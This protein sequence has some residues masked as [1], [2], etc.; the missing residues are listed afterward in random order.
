M[1]PLLLPVGR[2]VAVTA[3]LT[4]TTVTLVAALANPRRPPWHEIIPEPQGWTRAI[5]QLRPGMTRQEV[6]DLLG[7]PVEVHR[8]GGPYVYQETYEYP[9]H[10][11]QQPLSL[12]FDA[13][14]RLTSIPGPRGGIGFD[15]ASMACGSVP[16][17]HPLGVFIGLALLARTFLATPKVAAQSI[18]TK[19]A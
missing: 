1:D 11:F 3:G 2:F 12:D 17:V 5:A 4:A 13:T 14:G 18:R 19:G 6:V 15:L 8:F 9:D 10:R 16:L 7:G